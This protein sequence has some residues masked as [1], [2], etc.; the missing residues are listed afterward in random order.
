MIAAEDGHPR[1]RI[2]GFT[3]IELMV[4][5]AVL[6]ILTLVAA[7]SFLNALSRQRIQSLAGSLHGALAYARTEAVL[8]QYGVS[9]CA[10]GGSQTTCSGSTDYSLGWLIYTTPSAADTQ[11]AAG[12]DMSLLRVG[13]GDARVAAMAGTAPPIRFGPQGQVI[14]GSSAGFAVCARSGTSGNGQSTAAVPGQVLRV[15]AQGSV[16]VQQSAV[17]ASCQAPAAS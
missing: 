2:K 15:S 9:I 17:Q 13:Q 10:S 8:R 16:S 5:L 3:L 6:A 4:A 12:G 1:R 14:G 11:Y 7:P